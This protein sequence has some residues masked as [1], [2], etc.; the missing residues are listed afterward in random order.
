[1]KNPSLPTQTL[2]IFALLFVLTACQNG[3][4][5]QQDNNGATSVST[6]GVPPTIQ[7]TTEVTTTAIPTV[8]A[9]TSPI[10]SDEEAIDVLV[11]KVKQ[12]GIYKDGTSLDCLSFMVESA[13]ESGFDIAVQEKH[14]DACPGDPAV[15]PVV[16]RFHVKHD[17]TIL[18]LDTTGEYV[19]YEQMKHERGQ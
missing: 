5:T 2:L 15:A 11:K 3:N 17:G 1:M 9:A 19:D 10:A 13:D 12:D 7:T 8:A 16:D 4:A 14:G 6:Q 18:W